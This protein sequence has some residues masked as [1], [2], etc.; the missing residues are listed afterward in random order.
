[1]KDPDEVIKVFVRNQ[2]FWANAMIKTKV[3]LTSQSTNTAIRTG[4][5]SAPSFRKESP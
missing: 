3:G 4:Y 2:L 1:M 5:T